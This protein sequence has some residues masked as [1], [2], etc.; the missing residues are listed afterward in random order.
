M[1][2]SHIVSAKKMPNTL[3]VVFGQRSHLWFDLP[4][5]E[6]FELLQR[7]YRI[8]QTQYRHN[9][10]MF[11]DL[12]NLGDFFQTPV[13]QLSLGQRM[14]ADIAAALLHNPDVLFL[15]EPT[16]GLDIVAKARIRGFIE[17]INAEREVTVVLT[18]HDL[19]DVEKL[20]KRVILY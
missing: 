16:I 10:E 14:R 12:L 9:V 2:I 7:I 3:E 11:D 5:Q 4:V 8:P 20:C 13:R 15:D 18:T 1:D 19:D 6:S 17:K